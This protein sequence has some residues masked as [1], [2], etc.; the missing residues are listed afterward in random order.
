MWS[1]FSGGVYPITFGDY[2]F[3]C[4]KQ[5]N[6]GVLVWGIGLA[7]YGTQ[8]G[9]V[10]LAPTESALQDGHSAFVHFL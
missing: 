6:G 4:H 10:V 7:I 9:F 2:I 5:S 1:E 3:C 8:V